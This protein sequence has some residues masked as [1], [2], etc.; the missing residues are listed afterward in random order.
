MFSMPHAD[1]HQDACCVPQWCLGL[2]QV[3]SNGRPQHLS[4]VRARFQNVVTCMQDNVLIRKTWPILCS[5]LHM[6]GSECTCASSD[7]G[8]LLSELSF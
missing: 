7:T 4:G 3:L 8:K 1:I 6:R 5:Q 2:L